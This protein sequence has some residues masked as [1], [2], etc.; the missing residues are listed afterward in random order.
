MV[1][2]ASTTLALP[3]PVAF[4]LS[5]GTSLGAIQVG[6]LR[7]LHERGIAPDVL[8]GSSVGSLNAAY[9]A[10]GYRRERIDALTTLWSGLR[11][12]DVFRSGGISRYLS[13]L[14]GR[15][16]LA[17]ADRLRALI[18]RHLPVRQAQL[19]IPTA[20]I[21]T[22]LLSGDAVILD[23][24]DLVKNLLASTA[25][26]GVFPAVEIGGRILAD[27]A[28]AAHVP[29]LEAAELGAASIVV[30]DTGYPCALSELPHGV[31]P[32]VIHLLNLMLRHQSVA[33]LSLLGARLPVLYLP[34]PCPLGVAPYDFT[35]SA[36]LVESG[37]ASAGRYLAG[38][39]LAGPGIYGHPHFQHKGACAEPEMSERA[40]SG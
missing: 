28:I 31:V 35:H 40:V 4:V 29:I 14:R 22:D 19:A 6:M 12:L 39:R 38:V 34:S 10:G 2:S 11:A 27:G 32:S 3:H 20:V 24:G 17:T 26:P 1:H 36:R 8:V 33:S 23:Q 9:I 30:L 21:A 25:I 18:E 13:A 5:G 15:S 37:H 7:A 16:S